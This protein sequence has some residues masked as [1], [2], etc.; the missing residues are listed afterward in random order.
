MG[1]TGVVLAIEGGQN[2]MSFFKQY[3]L[4]PRS[5]G[6]VKAS[7]KHLA[8][9]MIEDVNFNEA[10]NI[11]EIGAGTGAFTEKLVNAKQEET[12]LLIFEIN[13]EFFKL[14]QKKYKNIHNVYVIHD[15]AEH[16]SRQMKKHKISKADYIISGLPFASLPREISVRILKECRRN[17]KMGGSFI[18]FQYTRLK[19][20]FLRHFFRRISIKKEYKNIPPAYILNCKN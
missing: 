18:T 13:D 2:H 19:I 20:P 4:H 7:S 1:G 6:A 15:T 8:E 11:I 5:V 3:I 9:K 12:R 10:E 14:L 17:L 16:M